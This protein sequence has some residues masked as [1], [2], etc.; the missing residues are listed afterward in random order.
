MKDAAVSFFHHYRNIIGYLEP[1]DV[2][3]ET[4]LDDKLVY[5][6]FHSHV[7]DFWKLSKESSNIL[8]LFYE[9]MKKNLEHEV[10]KTM[11]FLDKNY[12]QSEIDKLCKH[13]SFDSMKKNPS[14]NWEPNVLPPELKKENKE[15][16]EFIR[17]GKTGSHKKEMTEEQIEKFN[18]YLERFCEIPELF[19]AFNGN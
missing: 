16:F 12:S 5:S 11:K 4:F 10:K 13:L 2:F 18:N 1:K 15:K 8:F 7:I 19:E 17:E 6:P 9:D 3:Y 14:C